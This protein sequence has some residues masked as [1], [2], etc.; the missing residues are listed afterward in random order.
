MKGLSEDAKRLILEAPDSTKRTSVF[1]ILTLIL[2]AG[3]LGLSFVGMGD[4]WRCDLDSTDPTHAFICRDLR[5]I[6]GCRNISGPI[7]AEILLNVKG[8]VKA[9]AYMECSWDHAISEL[10]VCFLLTAGL[11]VLLGLHALSRENRKNAELF[12]QA[13]FFFVFLIIMSSTF[14]IFSVRDAQTNNQDVCTLSGAFELAKGIEGER[15]ECNYEFFRVTALY[16]YLCAL[17]LLIS[18][19]QMKNWMATLAV[20]DL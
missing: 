4:S 13:C 10:R 20:D 5:S 18:G 1:L 8:E 16:G 2:L 6:V 14:D 3:G 19:V 12:I 9:S 7:R 15:L 11:A 17:S